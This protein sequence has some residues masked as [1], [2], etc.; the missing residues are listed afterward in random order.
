MAIDILSLPELSDNFI[1]PAF[2]QTTTDVTELLLQ[3]TALQNPLKA[4]LDIAISN[5]TTSD[6]FLTGTLSQ[7][8]IQSAIDDMPAVDANLT[9]AER[10]S[11]LSDLATIKTSMAAYDGVT[12]SV[13]ANATG[14]LD[15][16]DLMV[17]NLPIVG[18]TVNQAL[19]LPKLIQSDIPGGLP[20]TFPGAPG[21]SGIPNFSGLSAVSAIPS[22]GLP[23]L[24]AVPG[25]PD[26]STLPGLNAPGV[27]VPSDVLTSL[28]GSILVPEFGGV[29][30][31]VTGNAC[32][33][34]G[35]AVTGLT[36]TAGAVQGILDNITDT[37][38]LSGLVPSTSTTVSSFVPGLDSLA[39]PFSDLGGGMSDIVG[40][41]VGA[42]NGAGCT[43]LAPSASGFQ[44]ESAGAAVSQANTITGMLKSQS[45]A[46]LVS[47]TAT[48]TLGGIV[49]L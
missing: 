8:S 31:L 15:H 9:T 6:G 24:S 43:T 11:L 22:L 16:S 34:A 41:E 2:D 7:A 14:L 13:L 27:A 39:T 30:S 47:S 38:A 19:S 45:T 37:S 3:D 23:D 4:E 5:L 33:L 25:I 44:C 18:G 35:A 42:L 49:G 29:G 1:E 26:A 46:K 32:L 12:T 17:Q 28:S 21:F 40:G 48:P 10:D 20:T 36:P